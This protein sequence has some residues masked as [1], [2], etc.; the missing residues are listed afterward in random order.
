MHKIADGLLSFLSTTFSTTHHFIG[1]ILIKFVD[2]NTAHGETYL[3]AFHLTHP[4]LGEEQLQAIMGPRR[5]AELGSDAHGAYEIVVGGR[6]LDIFECRNDEWR[7]KERR[8]LYDFTTIRAASGL[9]RGEGVSAYVSTWSA[10][11][12]SDPSYRF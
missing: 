5:F 3:R 1:N 11:D 6:Y 10:R 9:T 4:N 7:I 2:Q 12:R 8:L